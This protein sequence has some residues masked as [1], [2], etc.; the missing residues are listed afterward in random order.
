MPFDLRIDGSII[1]TF[2]TQ[3]EAVAAASAALRGDADLNLAITDTTTGQ[4][5][6]PGAS[7][8]WREELAGRMGY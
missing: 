1:G 7:A 6:A 5:V 3:A 2:E 4:P 8:S